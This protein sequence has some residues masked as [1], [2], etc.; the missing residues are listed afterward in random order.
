MRFRFHRLAAVA[1]TAAALAGLTTACGSDSGAGQ[2]FS[3]YGS[4]SIQ[5]P[6]NAYDEG[7]SKARGRLAEGLRLADHIVFGS[8]VAPEL[9]AGRGGKVLYG[10][11][12]LENATGVF[13]S[14]LQPFDLLGAY[15]A[16]AADT[17]YLGAHE[18]HYQ[19]T[20]ALLSFPD[21]QTATAAA[22]AMEAENFGANKDNAP[23]ALPDQ[24][25]ALSHWRPDR[26]NMG[27]WMAYK[28]VV[29][30]LYVQ[31]REV[32][33]DRLVAIASKAYQQQVSQ[34]ADYTPVAAADIPNLKLD[35][36]KLLTR[37]VRTGDDIPD[38]RDFAVYGPRAFAVSSLDPAADAKRYRD[39]GVDSIAVSGNKYL[40]QLPDSA[41]A[42]KFAAR[43]TADPTVSKYVPA[44]GVAD[45]PEISCFQA[46]QANPTVAG[47]RRFRCVIPH[48]KFVAEVFSNQEPDVQQLAAAEYAVLKDGE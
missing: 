20:V 44:A 37:L 1:L 42:G 17:A 47:A 26:A 2:E 29:I 24:P 18:D 46:T 15:I 7:A 3:R 11:H 35:R 13:A 8:D 4:Y 31:I 40:Y 22:A 41:A 21:D 33:L 23:I 30:A 16:D 5:R 9:T 6:G 10:A 27:S 34:L 48:G 25:A 14:A 19:L 38:Q 43:L 45:T 36:D 12:G 39:A 28:S 32:N